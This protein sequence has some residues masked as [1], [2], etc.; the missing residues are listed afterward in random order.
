[1]KAKKLL[2]VFLALVLAFAG[3]F[4]LTASAAELEVEKNCPL[5]NVTGFMS[6]PLYK[7]P[8]TANEEK[9][10]PPSSDAI[11]GAVKEVLPTLAT[12]T[13]TKDW[14]KLSKALIPAIN[15]IFL[16]AW[17]DKN[18]EAEKNTGAD[19]IYPS[20]SILRLSKEINFRYDWRLS[21]IE[22]AAQLND[23]IEYVCKATGSEKV[24]LMP[25]SCGGVVT[26]TY[27]ALYGRDRL[28]GVVMDSTAVFGETYT[29]ELL[30]GKIELNADAIRYF[31]SYVLNGTE[32]QKLVS[33][34]GNLLSK[35]GVLDFVMKFADEML[36]G[37]KDKVIPQVVMP[38]FCRW[39]TIWAMCPDEYLDEAYDYIF[40]EACDS[41][42]EEYAELISKLK[43]FDTKVRANKKQ[44]L[45]DTEKQ[46]RFGV[47]SAYGYS[48]VPVTASWSSSGDGVIDAKYTSYGATVAPI[49]Q[50]LSEE[51]LKE[52]DTKY[53]SP[54]KQVDASTCLFPEKTWFVK[55]LKHASKHSSLD[56]LAGLIL[57][58]G[59]DVTT[60]T[61]EKYPQFL[62]YDYSSKKIVI[63]TDTPQKEEE[64]TKSS[65]FTVFY[66][67]ILKLFDMLKS[68]ISKLFQK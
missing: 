65:V 51:Y 55:E 56:E 21:P 6:G 29:G 43:E 60:S 67:A 38:L 10:W 41:N 40:G 25:H 27:I 4:S 31:L 64:S 68:Y 5:I 33:A 54:D 24:C 2:C 62:K 26:L 52:K 12:V 1:M 42:P 15:K 49:G 34:V 44:L 46:C 17:L 57:Y 66:S 35:A 8:G 23:F 39:Q 50:T 7:N 61:F 9:I 37:I 3:L 20:E 63:N 11:L 45:L 32:Y 16:P 28:Q 36:A 14:D 59:K 48:S 30:T 58:S 47:I 19:F 13:V 53:I 22:I 18:G